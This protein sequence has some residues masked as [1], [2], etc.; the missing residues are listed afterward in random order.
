MNCDYDKLW[1]AMRFTSPR[2]HSENPLV[3]HF[4][5]GKSAYFQIGSN[6]LTQKLQSAVDMLLHSLLDLSFQRDYT[7]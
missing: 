5:H 4:G 3:L 6:S 1:E 2:W 7:K